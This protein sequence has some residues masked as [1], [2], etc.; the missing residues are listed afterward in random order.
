M[1]AGFFMHCLGCNLANK[2]EPV[3]VVFED[4]YVCC[5]L[6]HD[7]FNEGHILILPKKHYCD[8][9]ELD[10]T[11]ANAV[12][13]VSKIITKAIKEVY[14]PDGISILQNGGIF[15]D[16]NHYHMHLVPRYERQSFANFFTETESNNID[17][18]Q[19]L[20][21]QRKLMKVISKYSNHV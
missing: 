16:L 15:N 4:K 11:C 13:R 21:S 14:N 20:L 6:D 2:K 1:R 19:L 5:F 10:E 3:Y 18:I 8:V 9:D 17:K 12:M 7:P